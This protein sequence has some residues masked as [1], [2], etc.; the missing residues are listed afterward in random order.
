MSG[1]A[2][3]FRVR[4]VKTSRAAWRHFL[5]TLVFCLGLLPLAAAEPIVLPVSRP[6]GDD[7]AFYN[8]THCVFQDSYGFIWYTS[9]VG[10]HRYDGG[11]TRVFRYRNEGQGGPGARAIGA[12]CEDRRGDLWLA[13]DTG[14]LRFDRR[15]ETI[16][17][18]PL[19]SRDNR[20][21]GDKAILCV[22]ILPT[23]PDR[24]WVGT[25]GDGVIGVSLHSRRIRRYPTATCGAV[26]NHILADSR[27]RIWVAGN[28]GLSRFYPERGEFIQQP[29]PAGRSAPDNMLFIHESATLPGILWLASQRYGLG[30]YDPDRGAWEFH[31]ILAPGQVLPE[32]ATVE[33][34]A[35]WPFSEGGLLLAT[36]LGLKRFVPQRREVV[37]VSLRHGDFAAPRSPRV[38]ALLRDRNGLLWLATYGSGLLQIGPAP[39]GAIG[40]IVPQ[41]PDRANPFPPRV[42]AISEA[43]DGRLWIY[44]RFGSGYYSIFSCDPRN[45]QLTLLSLERMPS[46]DP[47]AFGN[48]VIHAA[49]NGMLWPSGTRSD[50]ARIEPRNGR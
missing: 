11:H 6:R 20:G 42:S 45:L 5:V 37:D 43:A 27:G 8:E 14:L 23:A 28:R 32:L 3:A 48:R 25:E 31:T 7:K 18:F 12:I 4:R 40:L 24:L 15:H 30:R 39:A 17:R 38:A 29:Y 47:L 44:C 1:E 35:D 36:P 9:T 22:T 50:L 13:S 21:S 26:I 33:A 49:R 16:S 2:R 34:I 19:V 10:L 46:E 41:D